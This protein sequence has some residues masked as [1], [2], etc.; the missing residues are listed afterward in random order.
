MTPSEEEALP[1]KQY[2]F[3][4]KERVSPLSRLLLGINLSTSNI[5]EGEYLLSKGFNEYEL[6]SKSR[7]PS[8]RN[9]ENEYIRENLPSIIT[10][11]KKLEK[12]TAIEWDN[13]PSLQKEKT[14]EAHINDSVRPYLDES[15]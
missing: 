1:R 4:E 11:A 8:L 5:E 7:L 13:S 15:I 2:L 6:G 14:R 10:S 3:G 12:D 9:K